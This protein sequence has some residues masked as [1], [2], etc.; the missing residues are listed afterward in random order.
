MELAK[1]TFNF[2]VQL[3]LAQI[4]NLYSSNG[5]YGL[6]DLVYDQLKKDGFEIKYSKD[7][8]NTYWQKAKAKMA[9][10]D[11]R[12]LKSWPEEM[13]KI[14]L[15]KYMKS[16]LVAKYLLDKVETDG[17]MIILNEDTAE[18]IKVVNIVGY[19]KW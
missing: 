18:Q 11:K 16:Y 10:N 3:L 13:L 2:S 15:N 19:G 7:I 4:N 5:S 8:T 14:R 6:Y 12:L 17:C 1:P 9:R